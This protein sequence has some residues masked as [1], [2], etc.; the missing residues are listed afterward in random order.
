MLRVRR[1]LL[2]LDPGVDVLGVL[3]DDDEVEVVAQVSRAFVGLD[4]PDERVEVKSLAKRDIDAAK[5][6]AHGRGDGAF[7]RHLV[8]PNRFQDGVGQRGPKLG[9]GGL[10]RLLDVP[11]ELDTSGFEHAR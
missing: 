1:A 6:A 9:D 11:V 10:T 5:S 7:E 8:P 4:R 3:A 2:E